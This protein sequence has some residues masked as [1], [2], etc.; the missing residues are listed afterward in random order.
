MKDEK[1]AHKVL[2]LKKKLSMDNES[3]RREN[4][5]QIDLETLKKIVIFKYSKLQS[6]LMIF[7]AF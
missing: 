4:K 6:F 1:C 7:G 5:A 2:K 3:S